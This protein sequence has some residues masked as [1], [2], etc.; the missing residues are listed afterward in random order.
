MDSFSNSVRISSAVLEGL[1]C[2]SRMPFDRCVPGTLS[3]LEV[4][5]C[6]DEIGLGGP[7]VVLLKTTT[8]LAW[9]EVMLVAILTFIQ[10]L[11]TGLSCDNPHLLQKSSI[12]SVIVCV[13]V[14]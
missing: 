13:T 1:V 4:P 3:V 14:C 9:L 11:L 10:R 6:E 12:N 8:A 5:D 2:S 7:S